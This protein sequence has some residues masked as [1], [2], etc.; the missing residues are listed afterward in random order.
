MEIVAAIGGVVGLV[1]ALIMSGIGSRDG[2]ERA[3]PADASSND[4]TPD[5][6]IIDIPTIK[7]KE[8]TL[9]PPTTP[10]R[11]PSRM[12]YSALSSLTRRGD[13]GKATIK[14]IK[15]TGT[16]VK[17]PKQQKKKQKS[18][19]PAMNRQQEED[20][21]DITYKITLNNS[22]VKSWQVRSGKDLWFACTTNE[23]RGIRTSY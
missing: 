9:T 13:K 2:G 10:G 22:S 15:V 21:Y 5:K 7:R 14:D 19:T 12:L 17:H 20:W 23:E 16:V 6:E 3:P 11:S 4:V 8:P 18:N 1:F